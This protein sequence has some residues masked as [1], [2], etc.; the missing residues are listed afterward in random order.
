MSRI[1]YSSLLLLA[2]VYLTSCFPDPDWA[3]PN[4][5]RAYIPVYGSKDLSEIRIVAPRQVNNPGKIYVYHQFLLVNEIKQGIH[6]FENSDPENPQGLGFI[7][8][9]GNTDMAIK[10]DVLY[11]DHLGNLVALTIDDFASLQEKG[12]LPLKNWHL[13]IP[14]PT[15]AH[16]ECVDPSKGLV[17]GWKKTENKNF[18]CYA[19]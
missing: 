9:L 19:L 14:P 5:V 7:R 2:M 6:V 16:F 12:R 1:F 13:G 4:H 17:V 3:Q 8:M 18:D 10:D 15:G 11:A